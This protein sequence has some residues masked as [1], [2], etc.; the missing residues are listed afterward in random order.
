ME[1]RDS[2]RREW[3][4][5]AAFLLTFAAAKLVLHLLTSHGYGY[6]RDELYYLACSDR[7]AFGYVDQ[8]PLSIVLLSIQRAFLGDS[9]LAL[10]FLPAVA[11]AATVFLVG[12][13]TRQL[14][15][16]R[17]AQVLAMFA[18]LG[19]PMFLG[20]NHFF[21]MN[22]FDLLFWAWAAYLLIRILK[23]PKPHLWL[24]LGLVL[25]LGLEN[26]IS[27]LWLGFGL[28][29]G[30]LLTRNRRHLASPWPWAAGAIAGLVFLPHVL[31]Q[32]QNGWPTIEFMQNAMGLKMA[33]V[34]PVDFLLT[35]ILVMNPVFL[36][37]WLAGLAF[38]FFAPGGKEFRLLGWTWLAVFFLLMISGSSRANY[39]APAYT[40]LF[41]GGAVLIERGF[42][43]FGEQVTGI[44]ETVA[45]TIVIAAGVLLAPLGLPVLPVEMYVAYSE[46]LGIAP[47]TEERKELA[48]LPQFYADMHGW[49]EIVG[50]VAEVYNSLP[51]DEQTKAAIF[52]PNYGVAGA[53]DFFGPQHDLP[54]AISGHNNYW[55]W[56]P[57]GHTGELVLFI[58]G[59]KEDH[60]KSFDEVE[61]GGTTHCGY[62][63]PYEN[64]QPVWICRGLRAPL[65][66]VWPNAKHFD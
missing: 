14:G 20:L 31:W 3:L 40:W 57:R 1:E 59:R 29:V 63:M 7:L 56:G 60:Q 10:R 61:L 17:F 50:T 36:P 32:I 51:A 22:A 30:F 45:S 26:K 15:G 58:G 12:L 65:D 48:E 54:E 21:S 6:F 52:A 55:L 39:M 2:T 35:Q 19:V 37:I 43:R 62:C 16:E 42:E 34:S 5:G 28:L 44:L 41:A 47:S 4:Q 49:E 24:L 11:G 25:G 46:R 27:V 23:E 9:L 8:P 13:M 18:T 66:Q 38:F 64:N 53:I 33:D